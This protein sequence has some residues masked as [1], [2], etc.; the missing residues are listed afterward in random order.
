MNHE[1]PIH[2][3]FFFLIVSW[4][5]SR[6]LFLSPP[7]IFIHS[8]LFSFIHALTYKMPTPHTTHSHTLLTH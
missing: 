5:L 3:G 1:F 8:T 4:F 6:D 7:F 2:W